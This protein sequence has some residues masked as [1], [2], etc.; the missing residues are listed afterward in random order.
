MAGGVVKRARSGC[1]RGG[2]EWAYRLFQEPRRMWHRYLGRDLPFL[3]VLA[4][5]TLKERRG[6]GEG[7]ARSA[8]D[9]QTVL[10]P[11]SVVGDRA[12]TKEGPAIPRNRARKQQNPAASR[13][14]ATS[15]DAGWRPARRCLPLR[16][17]EASGPAPVPTPSDDA[18]APPEL[19]DVTS[20]PRLCTAARSRRSIAA[21][22]AYTAVTLSSRCSGRPATPSRGSGSAGR[23]P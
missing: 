8:A 11:R 22:T 17:R 3:V 14:R 6:R 18:G 19:P 1:R 5:R 4:L 13:R 9:V 2:L 16:L 7:A 12:D 15:A 23:R 10:I 21:G 20:P